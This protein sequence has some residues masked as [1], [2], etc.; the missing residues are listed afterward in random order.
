MDWSG[1][2]DTT[3]GIVLP[4]IYPQVRVVLF[5]PLSISRAALFVNMYTD[6][7]IVNSFR[8]WVILQAKY[9]PRCPN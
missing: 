8:I 3:V 4:P 6:S 9:D 5:L 1:E 7:T 2:A